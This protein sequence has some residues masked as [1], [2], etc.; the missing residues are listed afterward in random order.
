MQHGRMAFQVIAQAPAEFD[1][2]VG[3]MQATAVNAAPAAPT[4]DSAATRKP[5]AA[6]APITTTTLA[7]TV[8]ADRR[9]RLGQQAVHDEGLHR[10]P[11]AQRHEADGYRPE[12]GRHRSPALH[13]GGQAAKHRSNLARWIQHPQ[14]VKHGVL[15]PDLG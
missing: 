13:R 10:V 15:M 12:P 14:T 3:R 6:A 9:R 1:V 2:Y 5:A 11:L 8:S 7:A 4:A